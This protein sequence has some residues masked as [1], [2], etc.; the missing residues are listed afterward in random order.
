MISVAW[1]NIFNIDSCRDFDT[2]MNIFFICVNDC[3]P[4][5]TKRYP[6][7]AKTYFKPGWYNKKLTYTKDFLI[8]FKHYTID[9]DSSSDGDVKPLAAP[10]VLFEKSRL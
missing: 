9:S 5:T 8:K 7:S 6:P 4:I 10:L 2:L 1:N 3:F